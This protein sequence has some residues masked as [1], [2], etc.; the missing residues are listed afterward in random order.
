MDTEEITMAI[1]RST[2]AKS[3]YGFLLRLTLRSRSNLPG[4]LLNVLLL[5]VVALLLCGVFCQQHLPCIQ[6]AKEA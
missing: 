5:G 3:Q 4:G 1:W 2:S 6:K